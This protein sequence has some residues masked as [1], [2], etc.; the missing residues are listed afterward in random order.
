MIFQHE[1]GEVARRA[2][3]YEFQ[4]TTSPRLGSTFG[5]GAITECAVTIHTK[6][7]VSD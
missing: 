5:E 1:A 2:V 3:L 4:S 7:I 6:A